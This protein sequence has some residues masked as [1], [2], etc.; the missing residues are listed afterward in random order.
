MLALG[1]ATVVASANAAQVRKLRG[2]KITQI[3]MGTSMSDQLTDTQAEIC[4]AGETRPVAV[5]TVNTIDAHPT[6]MYWFAI[7]FPNVHRVLPYGEPGMQAKAMNKTTVTWGY[8]VDSGDTCV[9]QTKT[10][11]RSRTRKEGVF[12]VVDPYPVSRHLVW[13]WWKRWA[14]WMWDADLC[15]PAGIGT[16]HVYHDLPR[17]GAIVRYAYSRRECH[18]CQPDPLTK[19]RYSMWFRARRFHLGMAGSGALGQRAGFPAVKG[20]YS[21]RLHLALRQVFN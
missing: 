2:W 21:Y 20:T 3:T 15:V 12:F 14:T 19:T 9:V 8:P 16:G 18:S 1:V 5:S 4:D 6:R 11:T 17:D 10:C 13:V 7:Y